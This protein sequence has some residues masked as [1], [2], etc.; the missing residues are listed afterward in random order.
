MRHHMF[1]PQSRA[2]RCHP[3][4]AFWSGVVVCESCWVSMKTTLQYRPTSSAAVA[5][6]I[7]TPGVSSGGQ[8]ENDQ[9]ISTYKHPEPRH[10]ADYPR[11][12]AVL[13]Q[14]QRKALEARTLLAFEEESFSLASKIR[15]DAL[16]RAA[17]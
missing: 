1:V 16:R 3:T 17:N 13:T 2:D 7:S 6:A 4:P 8:S 12:Y 14:Q 11:E 10:R 15:A 9:P 5:A